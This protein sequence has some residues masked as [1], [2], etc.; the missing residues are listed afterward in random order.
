MI[1]P[2]AATSWE[3]DYF[4]LLWGKFLLIICESLPG[5]FFDKS[6]I[7]RQKC[8]ILEKYRGGFNLPKWGIWRLKQMAYKGFN[9]PTL[10]GRG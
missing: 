2:F 9:L 6:Y 3:G 4:L 8:V 10:Q 7:Y 5:I 1:V